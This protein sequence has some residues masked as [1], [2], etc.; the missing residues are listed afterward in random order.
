HAHGRLSPRLELMVVSASLAVIACELVLRLNPQVLSG[1]LADHAFGKYHSYS[2]GIYRRDRRLGQR[3]R[4]NLAT[5]AYFN[6][7]WWRHETNPAGYRGAR[8]DRADVV[9]LGDSMIYGHGVENS[10]TVPSRFAAL[11]GLRVANL[12]QPATS[13]LQA[14]LSF[15]E[16]GLTLRPRF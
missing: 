16:I 10:D 2:G 12:G 5:L 8:F 13:P 11:T 9:F 4:P 14:L 7:F 6:G 3:L 15:R 1:E